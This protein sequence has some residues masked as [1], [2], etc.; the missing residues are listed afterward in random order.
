MNEQEIEQFI[1]NMP[2]EVAARMKFGLTSEAPAVDA[3]GFPVGGGSLGR[4]STLSREGLQDECWKKFQDNPQINTAVRGLVG[5]LTGL[6]F[7]TSSAVW[8]I[9]NAI[10]KTELDPRN[11]LWDLWPKFAG[12]ALI[13]GELFLSLS[14]HRNG[15]VEV[16]FVD[17]KTITGNGDDDTG[18]I[19]HSRKP[20]FPL[21]YNIRVEDP[22]GRRKYGPVEQVPSINIARFPEMI[23][24][25]RTHSGWNREYQKAARDR[26]F[27][28][29]FKP[30]G[31]YRRFIV[32]WNKGM[33]TRRSTAYLRT[34]IK[35]INHYERLKE[36]E[37]DHKKACASH[38]F[39][40]TCA[41]L[42]DY[43][44]FMAMSDKDKKLSGV[45]APAR[46]GQNRV[47]PPGFDIKAIN[48]NLPSM[49][50]QDTDILDMV[51][52]GLNE[53]QDVMTG[54]ASGTFA[55]AKAQK[56]PYSDRTSDEIAY[57]ERWLRNEF[58]SA[59]FFL[60]AAAGKMDRWFPGEIPVGFQTNADG[61]QEIITEKAWVE[62]ERL[63]DINF[64]VSENTDLEGMAR[65]LFGVKHASLAEGLGIPRGVL[66]KKIGYANYK[67]M[68]M[69]KAMEDKQYPKLALSIDQE[70]VQETLEAEPSKKI[71]A[72]QA[73]Q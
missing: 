22:E 16:D 29:P 61:E 6:G 49:T 73:Q 31:G 40:T 70:A 13:E 7:E 11:R 26:G 50:G 48:P 38:L 45:G 25:A 65:A 53:P 19:Y 18:I 44:N 59:V 17:P 1:K 8:P 39:V 4:E 67:R 57:F 33:V 37:I 24:D 46:P 66:A 56:G 3:D 27:F 54:R 15:F 20:T 9:Q 23:A 63:I 35:W 58:W 14:I 64:P 52:S 72:E 71:L 34:T 12:R 36:Y 41:S 2:N 69:L 21:F 5:R 51:S 42:R 30:I 28:S 10:E 43:K 32:E 47:L 68:R 55:S 62:P 60:K